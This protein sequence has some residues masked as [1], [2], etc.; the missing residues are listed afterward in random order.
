[1]AH[2][3]P[4]GRRVNRPYGATGGNLNLGGRVDPQT[5]HHQNDSALANSLL[6]QQANGNPAAFGHQYPHVN[7]TGYGPQTSVH[8][9]YEIPTV[10][11]G[12]A[13]HPGSAYGS[14]REDS[15]IPLS[16]VAHLSALDAPM[17]ASFDSQGI[18]YIA[19]HGPVAASVP[20]KFGIE[21]P[22]SSL[23]RKAI[24]P[25][26]AVRN[27]SE[28][29]YSRDSRSKAP[30]L[31][32]SPL[33]SGDEG[34]GQRIMHSQRVAKPKM[35][36]ASLPRIRANDEWEDQ[37]LFGGEE[38]FL[39]T[40]LHDLL[41]PQERMRRLSRTDHEAGS[42]RENL[43]GIGSPP[44]A[45]SKFGSPS[46][47]SPS[48]YGA[49]FA[50]QK[51]EEESNNMLPSALGHV[52]SPLRNPS[53]QPRASPGL[54]ATSN[55][56]MSGDISPHF[57]S[58]PRQS[59]MSALSQQLS[60]TRLASR[61]ESASGIEATNGLHPG[62]ARHHSQSNGRLDRAVSSSSI[63]TSRID[64]EQGD[65]VFSMEEEEDNHNKRYSGG[66]HSHSSGSRASPRLGPIGGGRQSEQKRGKTAEAYWP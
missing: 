15:R 29:A 31:G 53:L 51:R 57:A 25:S 45:S 63:G 46:G 2:I 42:H 7:E 59:S 36:S 40:S 62:S 19:R 41:T 24:L 35:M 6:A 21:S 18:S 61:S 38:D 33:A 32:S 50:R 64:E 14:P 16:P 1:M 47:A 10:E 28:S 20:S 55:A 52:G 26:D 17:P 34:L 23:P 60:H 49:L 8:R 43:S 65:C 37:F 48:R 9:P 22:P 54:R 27:V 4:N 56:I 58:P 30:N 66:W 13:S 5:Y 44:E 3:L 12:Y 11:T 39:P